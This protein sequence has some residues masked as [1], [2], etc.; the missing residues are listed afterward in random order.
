MELH[1][2]A[3]TVVLLRDGVHGVEVL[4]LARPA[5]RGSFAG[6]W[7]FPG[8]RVDAGD[9]ETAGTVQ[10]LKGPPGLEAL[11]ALPDSAAG[12]AFGFGGA[13]AGTLA[14]LNRAAVRETL[15][16]TGLRLE[17]DGLVP[18]SR[19][20][21][22]AQVPRRYQTWFFLAAAP[23]GQIRL[24]PE[25]HTAWLWSGPGEA[26]RRHREGAVDLAP[27]TWVTLHH[28]RGFRST[29]AAL[30]AAREAEPATYVGRR[31][32]GYGDAAVLAWRGDAEYPGDDDHPGDDYPAGD[33]DGGTRAPGARHRLVMDGRNWDFQCSLSPGQ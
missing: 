19:W 22:P 16:E 14:A 2:A 4:L 27:P 18:L 30:A 10:D 17:A 31:L 7:A 32:P 29:A 33:D 13:A 3:A 11:L 12:G 8:G 20:V 26:L 23:E 1:G 5:D 24:S 21:P 6:A 28:L 25:E 15:E 9:F